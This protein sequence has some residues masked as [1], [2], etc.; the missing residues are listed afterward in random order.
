MK[1]KLILCFILC[2]IAVE[3]MAQDDCFN[4]TMKTAKEEYNNGDYNKAKKHF[5]EAKMCHDKPDDGDKKV[6]SWI[7]KCDEK[8]NP[9]QNPPTP[10]K[11]QDTYITVNGQREINVGHSAEG[12]T[13]YIS[14]STDAQSWESTH[15]PS[16]CKI[17][18]KS[19]TGF[20]LST[21]SNNNSL[22]D[23]NDYFEV[24]TPKGNTARINVIQQ[25]NPDYKSAT[26]KTVTVS[27]NEDVNG[28]EGLC[29]H[30]SFNIIGMKKEDALVS[31][32]FYDSDGKA[33]V[34]RNGSYNTTGNPSH[35][36]ASK[37]IKPGYDNTVYSD[38]QIK[39]PY[40]ELHRSDVANDSLKV[41]V[42]IWDKSSSESKELTRKDGTSFVCTPKRLPASNA[43]TTSS[44]IQSSAIAVTEKPDGTE[45]Q[46]NIFSPNRCKNNRQIAWGYKYSTQF[47]LTITNNKHFNNLRKHYWIIG[48][49]IGI[50][51][52]KEIYERLSVSTESDQTTEITKTTEITNKYNPLFYAMALTGLN[53]RIVSINFGVGGLILHDDYS[54]KT[55]S[56]TQD[57]LISTAEASFSGPTIALI[58]QPSVSFNIPI[59]R[60]SHYLSFHI[61]YNLI[62]KI[63]ELNGISCGTTF[64]FGK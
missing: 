56:S 40:R 25:G 29:V 3:S 1:F 17:D 19:M 7:K 42:V 58:L 48:S 18:Y 55:I 63:K 61:G 51:L 24:Q 35:V 64:S 41:R 6:D 14:I 28:K 45:V 2:V 32:Y 13:E 5:N 38:L 36:A 59:R 57:H 15:V 60:D 49:E 47:P 16:W 52:N 23:R 20:R 4:P 31:C 27:N 46:T 44:Q 53:L 33:L 22:L 10:P 26:I 54:H 62:P 39:I 43:T 9:A 11:Q 34:D 12:K 21:L 30:V 37:N 8:L 50:N